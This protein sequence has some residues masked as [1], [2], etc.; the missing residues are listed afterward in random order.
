MAK[1]PTMLLAPL[2]RRL[3]P[4]ERLHDLEENKQDCAGANRHREIVQVQRPEA[5]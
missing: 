5:E 1:G 2:D 3:S 4:P